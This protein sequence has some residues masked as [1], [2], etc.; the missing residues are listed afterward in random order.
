[1]TYVLCRMRESFSCLPSHCGLLEIPRKYPQLGKLHLW[2]TIHLSE[3]I[4]S[5][6][7]CL[8]NEGIIQPTDHKRRL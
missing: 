8:Q 7:H 2:I 6:I 1:M 5:N 3:K 4:T